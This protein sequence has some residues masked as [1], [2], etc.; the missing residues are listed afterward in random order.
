MKF[1]Y[2]IFHLPSG[3]VRGTNDAEIAQEFSASEEHVV[4]EV[5]T[6]K[7]IEHGVGFSVME[8]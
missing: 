4:V 5:E 1:H 3:V 7:E 2:Y 6:G 8:V